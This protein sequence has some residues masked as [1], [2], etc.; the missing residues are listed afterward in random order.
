MDL[1]YQLLVYVVVIPQVILWLMVAVVLVYKFLSKSCGVSSVDE[2]CPESAIELEEPHFT[3]FGGRAFRAPVNHKEEVFSVSRTLGT[4]GFAME[5]VLALSTTGIRSALPGALG[6]TT[7]KTGC[8]KLEN[9]LNMITIEHGGS[10]TCILMTSVK[11]ESSSLSSLDNS[12][13]GNSSE[14]MFGSDANDSYPSVFHSS[15]NSSSN[16]SQTPQVANCTIGRSR[17]TS[18]PRCPHKLL[19]EALITARS[20][21]PSVHKVSLQENTATMIEPSETMPS[22]VEVSNSRYSNILSSNQFNSMTTTRPDPLQRAEY[23]NV[24]TSSQTKR[25][26]LKGSWLQCGPQQTAPVHT[27]L[28]RSSSMYQKFDDCDDISELDINDK[29]QFLRVHRF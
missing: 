15:T 22:A 10:T 11:E 5:D 25:S 3:P 6:T 12:T 8:S 29:P 1:Q 17:M 24:S 21:R 14:D 19:K 28:T 4:S 16:S 9:I 2:E 23:S 13:G 7:A 18:T 26:L 27:S 20:T